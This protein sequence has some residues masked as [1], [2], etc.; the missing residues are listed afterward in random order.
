MP[1]VKYYQ[2]I[3]FL[4]F[5]VFFSREFPDFLSGWAYGGPLQS[6]L[7]LLEEADRSLPLPPYF[8]IDDLWL[9][10]EVAKGAGM[11]LRR[12][13]DLFTVYTEHIKCCV[14]E[15]KHQVGRT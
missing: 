5:P 6:I 15:K 9:S 8:W 7:S 11:E 10:G 12:M 14:E 3:H 13:N 1:Y 4:Q 2:K